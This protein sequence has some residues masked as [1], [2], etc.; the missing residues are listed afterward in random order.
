MA[1]GKK[2]NKSAEAVTPEE[3]AK[4]GHQ[5]EIEAAKDHKSSVYDHFHA[6][7]NAKEIAQAKKRKRRYGIILGTLIAVLLII[8]IISMLTT[9]WGDLV[10]T[11]ENGNGGKTILLSESAEFSEGN[12]V[13]LNGGSVK[14]VTNI[15]K[16]WLP[17]GLDEKDGSHNGKNYLAY[18]FYLKNTGDEDLD[19][20]T[21]MTLT[22][23]AKGADEATRIMIIKNGEEAVYAKGKFSD[24]KTAETD[25]T[26]W[27]TEKTI[28]EVKSTDLKAKS[29]DKYTVVI[30]IEGNDTECVDAIRG[31]YVRSQMT[32]SVNES[33]K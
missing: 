22:G 5:H 26:K 20:K 3:V 27:K 6:Q 11:V 21:T 23:Q 17:D 10:V 12:G 32:F 4:L 14:E 18:T 7:D 8:Y 29:Q 15:T 9:Q 31:G 25:A 16:S 13:K 1:F 19:Y 24:R 28:L 33:N 2:K 30:W